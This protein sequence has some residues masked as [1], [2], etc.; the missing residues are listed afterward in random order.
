MKRSKFVGY[1]AWTLL[2]TFGTTLAQAQEPLQEVKVW[3]TRIETG[4]LSFDE[5]AVATRQ[6]DHISDLLR[7]I[8]GVDVGG[9]HS[10][11]QRITIRSM[12]DK[13]L[14]ITIDGANQNTYMYHHMGNLQIH[15]DI[16]RS[17]EIELGNN[18]VINGGL[19]GTARFET[20]D[21]RDLLRPDQRAGA[22]LQAG[23]ATNDFRTYSATGYGNLSDTIDL[24]GYVNRVE[25]NDFEVGGGRITDAE[26]NTMPDT[27]GTVRGMAGDLTDALLK[28]GWQ[29]S[30]NQ[31]LRLGF[32]RYVDKGDY[33]YRPDMGL[34]TDL[35]MNE[36]TG[37][38]LLWPTEFA[39]DTLTLNYALQWGNHS[40]LKAALFHNLST[41]ERDETGWA[42]VEDWSDYA[43]I[44]SGEA[45]NNGLNVIVESDVGHH[46]LTYG[47]EYIEYD[48]EYLAN[49][50]LIENDASAESAK[51]AAVYLQ[52][53]IA[54]GSRF[55]VIPGVRYSRVEL[56][57]AV[58]TDSFSEIT[59]ALALEYHVTEDLL[60]HASST[61]LFKA[62]EIGEVFTGAG[63]YDQSNPDI[64]AETGTN[65]ELAI[66]W[67][68][69]RYKAGITGF[70]TEIDNYIYDYAPPPEGRFWKDNVGTMTIDGFEAHAGITLGNLDALLTFSTADSELD[71]FATYVD[72]NGARLDRKQGDTWSL[73]VDYEWTGLDLALH[74]EAMRVADL[75]TGK[76]LDG[77]TK[78][79]AKRGFTVHH[80]ALRWTPDDAFSGW[81]VTLGV[82]NLFDEFYA[83]QS[84]R[85]GVS[86]HRYGEL[87]L[88]DF[89]PGR[90][91]KT[92][93]SYQF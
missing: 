22:R 69:P 33:T 82:D 1:G 78:D 77:A 50:D 21:A 17:A 72:L 92:T 59:A 62:P 42:G 19:G 12:D 67:R 14:R 86:E 27:D 47:V 61:Q 64:D 24:L 49:Y 91:I 28:L 25:R 57:S 40:T 60:L 80:I 63:F 52:D 15:A 6:V 8:P 68:N 46:G 30:E 93:V 41:L 13:D 45:V 26:G 88:Q 74:W 39:R 37:G 76:D 11:N 18:S 36:G 10:M 84:S 75:P 29:V 65:N 70:Q 53:R 71:A 2:G 9:A 58:V 43:G 54:V 56:N 73:N 85:T 35:I 44:I 51:N 5:E 83:S 38:P 16:L 4:A 87:Y 89:E 48:T 7:T 31:Q 3:G 79:N 34:A 55:S 20:K 90:N 23:Y 32:E 66:A 81:T